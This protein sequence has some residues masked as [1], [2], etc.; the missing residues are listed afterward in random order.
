MGWV[1]RVLAW[2]VILGIGAIILIAV[3]IPRI[4]GATPYVVLT[5]SMRPTMPPGT[6]V[7]VRPA[8][9]GDVGIGDVV[10]YQLKSGDPTVVTHRVV[11][12]GSFRGEPIFQTQGDANH[13]ADEKWVRQVQIRGVKWYAVPYLGYVTSAITNSQ[14]QVALYAIV[15][16][17]LGYAAFMFSSAVRDRR[18]LSVKH[19]KHDDSIS[20][21]GEQP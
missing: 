21:R 19:V 13:V 5:G 8:K 16:F 10:T 17:L 2:T 7:V 15:T 18:R 11:A 12:M 20:T 9:S 4:A 6:M 1:G 3:L 14:R